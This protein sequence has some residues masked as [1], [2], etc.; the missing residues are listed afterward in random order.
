MAAS[1]GIA[2][3]KVPGDPK[4]GITATGWPV[5]LPD[6]KHFLFMNF[7]AN[8]EQTLMVGTLDSD[9]STELFKVTS[10][11]LYTDPGYLLFVR[12]NTLVAQKFDA[13]SLT[14]QGDAVPLGEGLGVDRWAWRR[15]R[16]REMACLRSAPASSGRRLVW[17]DRT[18]GDPPALDA[19]GDYRDAISP[20][21]NRFVF[22]SS[23]TGSNADVWIRD[24][25]RGVTSRFTFDAAA[26]IDSGCGPPTAVASPTAR[27]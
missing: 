17:P 2:K 25:V 3:V 19:L 6:G 24:L 9:Q 12:E 5:F 20:E 27:G 10:R 22:D 16:R 13:G 18:E 21:G 26:E 15:S 23:A 1:G 14:V 11:V 4:N 8:D 7:G